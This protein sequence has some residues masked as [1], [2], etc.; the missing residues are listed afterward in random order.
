MRFAKLMRAVV[1][2]VVASGL[3]F[4]EPGIVSGASAPGAAAPPADMAPMA[5]AVSSRLRVLVVSPHPDDA[6]LGAGGLIQRIIRRG[7][8]VEVVEM[9]SGDGFP[10]GVAAELPTVHPTFQTYR[11]YGSLREH[12]ALR[13]MHELGVPRSRIRLLGFPDEGL[14]QLAADPTPHVARASPY[15]R[16]DS[17]PT[18]ERILPGAMYRG[19]DVRGELAELLDV[20]RPTVV[21]LPDPRDDHPDHCATH[22]L[23]HDAINQAVARGLRRPAVLNYLIHHSGWPGSTAVLGPSS[24][25]WRV[26]RLTAS[27]R[28]TKKH[29]IESYRSQVIVMADFLRSFDRTEELF[30]AGDDQSVPPPCWCGGE[31]IASH[32]RAQ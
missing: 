18:A 31:N 29:A 6:T 8:S 32:G 23:V 4:S 3:Q 9:T 12:E 28:E 14:C 26:L 24:G 11:W 17:P 1:C 7:G 15:T 30:V 19:S 22:I 13:A 16:R 2:A 27:E 21:V 5:L 20:F 25:G 10:R